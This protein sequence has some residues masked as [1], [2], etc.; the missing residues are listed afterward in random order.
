M[1]TLLLAA[2]VL[3]AAGP[4][5]AAGPSFDCKTAKGEAEK[6]ICGDAAL[7]E[8]DRTL[9][10]AYRQ[11]QQ[12]LA[13]DAAA[14]QEL[15]ASQRSFIATRDA[16]F[17]HPNHSL[18]GLLDRRIAVLTSINIAERKTLLNDWSSTSGTVSINKSTGGL[19]RVFASASDEAV[20]AW[21]CEFTGFGRPKGDTVVAAE[22][23]GSNDYDGWTITVRRIGRMIE[24]TENRPTPDPTGGTRP[25]CGV[26]GSLAGRYFGVSDEGHGDEMGPGE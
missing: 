9:A 8:R 5:T 12:R 15:K 19:L 3:L 22:S 24:V 26:R 18:A 20:G 21:T 7:A 13:G 10:A 6:A 11:A 25:F 2:A 23:A 1:K 17:G 16:A 4:A 14:L